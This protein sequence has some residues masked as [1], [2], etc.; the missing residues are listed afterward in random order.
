MN[1]GWTQRYR[2]H[3][4]RYLGKPFDC[5]TFH[6]DSG[7][8]LQIL[9][10]DRPI[11]NYRI[12]ASLGLTEYVSEIKD[13]G[14]VIVVTD[15]GWKD[16][17]FLLVNALFFAIGRR[18]RLGSG[19]A[20]AGV[21]ALHPSFA[22]HFDKTALYFTTAEGFPAGFD[23]VEGD[24]ETGAIHQGIFISEAENEHVSRHGAE[25]FEQRLKAQESDPRSLRRPSCI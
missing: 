2:Q 14:E 10:F 11:K 18:I 15:D 24:H 1:P 23:R 12:F 4:T 17:A 7:T 13:L 20:I 19:L 16:I 5:E 21:E 22:A 3:F 6:A 9:T 8:S 25:S